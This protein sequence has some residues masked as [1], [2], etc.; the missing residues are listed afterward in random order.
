[1]LEVIAGI[2]ND[3]EVFRREDLSEPVGELRATDPAS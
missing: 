1:M 3:R 2:D